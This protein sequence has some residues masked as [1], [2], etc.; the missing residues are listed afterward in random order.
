MVIVCP[1]VKSRKS[2]IS[3]KAILINGKGKNSLY[4]SIL[5]AFSGYNKHITKQHESREGDDL[6]A[7]KSINTIRK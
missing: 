3:H 2:F 6:G 1:G 4:K 5:L 7:R